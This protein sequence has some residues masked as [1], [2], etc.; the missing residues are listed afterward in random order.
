MS[1][2]DGKAMTVAEA[3]E[4]V[5]R[6]VAALQAA[7]G[8]VFPKNAMILGSGLGALA[9]RVEGAT[10]IS[11]SDIP[12]F[13]VPTVPGHA[14]HLKLGRLPGTLVACLAE[15]FHAYDG[16]APQTI[17]I[18]IRILRAMGVERIILTNASGGLNAQMAVGT[19]M[20]VRDHINFTG[21]NPLAGPNDDRVGP[22]FFD[23][24]Y[25]YDPVLREIFAAASRDSGVSVR[26]GV[27]VGVLG[28]SFETP[29]EIRMFGQWGGDAVGMS[30]VPECLAAVHCGM[31]VAALSLI[32]NAGAGLKPEPLSHED[33]MVE[34]ARAHDRAERLL[35]AFFARLND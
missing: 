33:V 20:V 11:Y 10:D 27:Y 5:R 28:P 19:L 23:M 16:H 13:P 32:T 14:G 6:G 9:D 35:L 7:H 22:R 29:A 4:Q 25:A 17:V 24:T 12:G 34:G 3:A 1:E 2:D 21:R 8:G 18:P 31:K 15:R 30:T 26:E